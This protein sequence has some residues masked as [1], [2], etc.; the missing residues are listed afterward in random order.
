[1]K[2]TQITNYLKLGILLFGISLILASCQKDDFTNQSNE[3][4]KTESDFKITTLRKDKILEK[5]SLL[6]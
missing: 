5:K 2:Q 3:S 1:M 6:T 4:S